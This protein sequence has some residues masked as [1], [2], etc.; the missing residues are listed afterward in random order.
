VDITSLQ[1]GEL[2]ASKDH[3]LAEGR[4]TS[5]CILL[6]CIKKSYLPVFVSDIAIV[7]LKRDAKLQLTN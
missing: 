2:L 6:P 5:H 3:F 7:V 4:D 1:K